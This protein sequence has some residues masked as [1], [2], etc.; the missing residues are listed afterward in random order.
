VRLA[1]FFAN[2]DQNQ[3]TLLSNCPAEIT[4]G[5][6]DASIKEQKILQAYDYILSSEWGKGEPPPFMQEKR[7]RSYKKSLN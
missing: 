7:R 4:Y 6:P 1:P 2:S 3:N 5:Q